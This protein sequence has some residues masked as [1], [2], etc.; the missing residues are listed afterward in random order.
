[1]SCYVKMYAR[2]VVHWGVPNNPASYYQ[3]SG[4]AGRDGNPSHCRI[5]YNKSD[6]NAIEFHL[7]QDLAKA[8]EKQARKHK[9]HNDINSFTKIVEFCETAT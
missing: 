5:Y 7:K 2:F 6:R 1:M 9:V 4:R 3:E 8:N